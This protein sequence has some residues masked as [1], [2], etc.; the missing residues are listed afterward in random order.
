MNNIFCWDINPNLIPTYQE[1][2]HSQDYFGVTSDGKYGIF[3]Y[4]ILELSMCA[5]YGFLAIYS[6]ANLEVPIVSLEKRAIYFHQDESFDYA[7]QSDCLAF[8][9]SAYNPNAQKP[10]FPFLFIK[11]F[12]QHFSLLDWDNSSIYYGFKEYSKNFLQMYEKHPQEISSLGQKSK[13]TQ[14][15]KNRIDLNR[16]IWY[17]TKHINKAYEIYHNGI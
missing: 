13:Y 12:E 3:I 1:A 11:P 5:Y 2:E 7:M 17:N 14:R 8:S 9:F 10:T 6:N 15:T 4:N 16:M